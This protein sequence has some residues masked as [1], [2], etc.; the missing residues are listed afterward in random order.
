LK[1]EIKCVVLSISPLPFIGSEN[2]YASRTQGIGSKLGG[3]CL[4]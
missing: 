3:K 4:Y 2:G 1:F